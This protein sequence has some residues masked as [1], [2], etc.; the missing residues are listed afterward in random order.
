M[1]MSTRSPRRKRLPGWLTWLTFIISAFMAS[2]VPVRAQTF[3]Q[4]RPILFVH[5]FCG[6]ADSWANLAQPLSSSLAND[7]ADLYP[8]VDTN[9]S[10]KV[11]KVHY[12]SLAD[13]V[14]FVDPD[15]G[16]TVDEMWILP[17]TRF[18]E[19]AFYDSANATFDATDVANISIL[20]KAYE[21]SRVI[22][23]ITKITRIEDVIVVAHSMGGLVARAYMENLA[24]PGY[25]W[26]PGYP[27]TPDYTG[28]QCKPGQTPWKYGND[29]ADLIT[30]DTPHGG[31]LASTDSIQYPLLACALQPSTTK[32]EMIPGNSFLQTLN[33]YGDPAG[34]LPSAVVPST[35]LQSIESYFS[36]EPNPTNCPDKPVSNN[37]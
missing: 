9:K 19:I 30:I 6:D 29:I 24:S 20:N 12:D 3:P 34:Q 21:L 4:S 16:Q 1:W 15:N 37:G 17:S 33:Y 8:N 26:D 27:S 25:C 7:Y 14:Y 23:E 13:Q 35:P 5:G 10:Q 28:S 2:F 11:Y 36:N 31:T 32:T 18:F 22:K